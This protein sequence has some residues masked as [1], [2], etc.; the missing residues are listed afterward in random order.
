MSM[1]NE[2]CSAGVAAVSSG[3]DQN[4][5]EQN[6]AWCIRRV[7]SGTVIIMIC[8]LKEIF[9]GQILISSADEADKIELSRQSSTS[10]NV[11]AKYRDKQKLSQSLWAWIAIYQILVIKQLLQRN[12]F[13]AGYYDYPWIQLKKIKI[14]V[15]GVSF[16]LV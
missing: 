14:E 13:W 7:I 8:K 5:Q 9:S 12:N 1:W 10:A 16:S 3:S 6:L 4:N 2:D 15:G 11:F